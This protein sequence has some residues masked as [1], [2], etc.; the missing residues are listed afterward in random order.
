MAGRGPPGPPTPDPPPAPPGNLTAASL[1]L[2]VL[3]PRSALN[4]CVW[5]C[6]LGKGRN[7]TFTLCSTPD[8]RP[9][10]EKNNRLTPGDRGPLKTHSVTLKSPQFC[11]R[12]NGQCRVGTCAVAP[13]APGLMR[14]H[15]A[16]A[17]AVGRRPLQPADPRPGRVPGPARPRETRGPSESSSC[18][19]PVLSPSP[20]QLKPLWVGIWPG[21]CLTVWAHLRVIVQTIAR[22]LFQRPR[23]SPAWRKPLSQ[24]GGCTAASWQQRAPATNALGTRGPS[25]A[26]RVASTPEAALTAESLW[27]GLGLGPVSV[28]REDCVPSTVTWDMSTEG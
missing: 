27:G 1:L 6:R 3:A 7:S 20:P 15:P 8:P 11:L 26:G 22:F 5:L 19:R 14:P 28:V 25:G 16:G 4:A 13:S 12:E 24:E 9:L 18:G 21:A 17:P 10:Q 23:R 2:R